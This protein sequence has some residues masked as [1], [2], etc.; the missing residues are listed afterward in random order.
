MSYTKQNFNNG[1]TLTAAH[2]NA[3]ENGILNAYKDFSFWEG[4]TAVCVG[5]SITHGVG[6]TK[7][8]WQMLEE[9]LKLGKVIGMGVSGSCVSAKSDYGT[10]RE[11]LINRWQNIPDADLITLF[12]GTNDYG[13]GTPLGTI[14]DVG[15]ISFYGALNV[16][17]PGIIEAHPNS[18]LVYITPMHRYY[19]NVDEESKNASG[20]VLKDYVDAIKEVCTRYSVPVVDFFNDVGFYP[21]LSVIRDLYMPDG[22]HPNEAGHKKMAYL[23]QKWLN[24]YANH[25]TIVTIPVTGVELDV[26]SSPLQINQTI[27]ITASILPSNA[28][29][30]NISWEI[31]SGNTNISISSNKNVCTVTGLANGTAIIEA[32]TSDGSYTAQCALTVTNQSIPV[33]AVSIISSEDSVSVNGSVTLTAKLQPVTSTNQN[34]TWSI[35]S[36]D[37]YVS[38]EPNGLNCIVKGL[39]EGSATIS[40]AT[41]DGNHQ[42]NFNIKVIK[43]YT[44]T[45]GSAYAATTATS[46]KRLSINPI[47]IVIPNNVV[48]SPKMGYDL[49]IFYDV[50]VDDPTNGNRCPDGWKT[51]TYIGNGEEAIGISIRKEDEAEFDL[52]VDATDPSAYLDSTDPSIWII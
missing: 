2:L 13:H 42:G 6:T 30:Q 52:T 45:V 16:I 50:N 23:L 38:I 41:Q 18:R 25:E 3:M 15:D 51:E 4:K 21:K 31:K 39:A 37:S 28:T 8:Y 22:I 44:V 33:S 26:T 47:T 48:I 40:V 12:I 5:D 19:K 20:Y 1:Q 32:K 34:V 36:G 24:V 27:A 35:N 49:G 9:I 10:D 29:N 17:I 46:K 11:P 14:T 43:K 7:I